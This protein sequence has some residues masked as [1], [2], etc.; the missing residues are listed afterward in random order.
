MGFAFLVASIPLALS[1]CQSVSGSSV[2]SQVRIID[3]S[4]D[5]PG[6]DIYQGTTAFAYNLGFGTVTSYVPID[7]RSFTLSADATGTRQVLTSVTGS[8]ATSGQYTVLVSNVAASIQSVILKDQSGAAPSG[9]IAFRFLDEVT[10]A[11]SVDVYLVPSGSAITTV[12]PTLTSQAFG[13]NSGYVNVPTGAYKIVVYPAGTTPTATSVALYS[14]NTV[15]YS[16]GAARTVLLLNQTVVNTP[17]VQ[18][19]IASDYD[20]PT[21]T[22]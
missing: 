17:A 9:Q 18:V 1:G 14:G 4:P 15:T 20:S 7:P 21:A 3:A 13:S 5:A 22:S 6:L 12:L 19:V 11:T 8:F 10:A 16:S 2:S